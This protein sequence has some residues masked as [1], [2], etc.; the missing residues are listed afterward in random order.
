MTDQNLKDAREAA[1]DMACEFYVEASEAL[2]K[3]RGQK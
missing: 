3:I 2:Q 1:A